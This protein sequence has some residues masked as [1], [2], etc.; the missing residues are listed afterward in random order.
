MCTALLP[1]DGN[2]IAVNKYIISYIVL[3]HI[4]YHIIS[5]IISFHIIWRL[6]YR[7]LTRS[8]P[9]LQSITLDC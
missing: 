4:V 7:Y 1:P 3:Y 6:S 5:Y 9:E 8:R 2:P